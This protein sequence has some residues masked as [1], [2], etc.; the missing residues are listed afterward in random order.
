MGIEGANTASARKLQLEESVDYRG[1]EPEELL[2]PDLQR[3][4][5]E[6][7]SGCFR[8]TSEATHPR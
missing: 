1:P 8:E 6:R 3:K 2:F 4:H 5:Q 7:R